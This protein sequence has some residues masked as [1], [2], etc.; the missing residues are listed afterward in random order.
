MILRD[1]DSLSS[2]S[3]Q[4]WSE[5][6]QDHPWDHAVWWPRMAALGPWRGRSTQAYQI[7]VRISCRSCWKV[8]TRFVIFEGTKQASRHLILRTYTQTVSRKLSLGK[9]SNSCNSHVKRLSFSPRFV[10]ICTAFKGSIYW[11][12]QVHGTVAHEYR[13]NFVASCAKPDEN[14]YVNQHGLSR[15]VRTFLFLY[16]YLHFLMHWDQAHLWLGTSQS[17]TSWSGLYWYVTM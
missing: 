15:K 2:L 10:C 13:T 12:T 16:F 8:L 11:T 14:G 7:C 9:P 5:S 6:V 3:R 1:T 17:Q 4:L